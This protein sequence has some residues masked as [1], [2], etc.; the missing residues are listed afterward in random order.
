MVGRYA[1][2]GL[3]KSLEPRNTLHTLP[4]EPQ[5]DRKHIS[6]QFLRYLLSVSLLC[7][8]YAVVFVLFI[9]VVIVFVCILL[10]AM[11]YYVVVVCFGLFCII[12][13]SLSL[14]LSLYIYITMYIYIY[15]YIYIHIY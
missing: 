5:P 3:Q 11:C 8:V 6:H 9:A 7:I 10:F 2:L 4:S 1:P 14:S 12:S 15:I 13:L